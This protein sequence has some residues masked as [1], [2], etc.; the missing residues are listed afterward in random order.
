M[1][2]EVIACKALLC[3]A[4]CERCTCLCLGRRKTDGEH[5]KPGQGYITECA[6]QCV[7][8]FEREFTHTKAVR[9]NKRGHRFLGTDMRAHY[10]RGWGSTT[11]QIR[12]HSRS[13]Q[14]SEN[15]GKQLIL[16]L[17]KTA[18]IAYQMTSHSF[19]FG[20]GRTFGARAADDSNRD[21]SAQGTERSCRTTQG[22]AHFKNSF[23]SF[24]F[25]SITF[26]LN[27]NSS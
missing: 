7:H 18:D 14:K 11:E 16:C 20:G 13:V 23:S 25:G 19:H 9:A 3:V 24:H 1:I 17:Q 4:C 5:A 27:D 2:T 10:L 15:S 8:K 22:R 21:I 6:E 12:A 26:V